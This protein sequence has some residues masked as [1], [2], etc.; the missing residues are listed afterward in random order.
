V[1]KQHGT[2]AGALSGQSVVGDLAQTLSGL[3]TYSAPGSSL[4]GLD[5]LGLSLDRTG[6]LTFNQFTLMAADI[7]NSAG[8]ASFIGT[9][10]SGGFLQT[11]IAALNQVLDPLTGSAKMAESDVQTQITD[12]N[13]RINTKQDQV[14]QLQQQLLEQMSAVDALIASME[15]QYSYI[16]GMFQA[17]QV[18]DQQ[19]R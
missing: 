2:T 13:K 17:M 11:A 10:T 8:V 16:S 4:S 5:A 6:H 1:D 15:Q 9:P 14:D 19:Y 18:A 7:S 3:A 12:T